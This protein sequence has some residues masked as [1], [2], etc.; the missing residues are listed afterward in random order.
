[1]YP[2]RKTFSLLAT[3]SGSDVLIKVGRGFSSVLSLISASSSTVLDVFSSYF[4][5]F[6]RIEAIT[7]SNPSSIWPPFHRSSKRLASVPDIS[8]RYFA[9]SANLYS[10]F[11]KGWDVVSSSILFSDSSLSIIHFLQMLWSRFFGD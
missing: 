4:K 8:L 6:F 7:C 1:M 5:A 11:L 3:S 2:L 9:F 10:F